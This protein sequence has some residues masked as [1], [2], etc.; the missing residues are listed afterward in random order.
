MGTGNQAFENVVM[1]T[2][3]VARGTGKATTMGRGELSLG[4]FVSVCPCLGQAL[5]HLELPGRETL[6]RVSSKGLSG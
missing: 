1:V 3:S 6:A 2:L 5:S 4:Q